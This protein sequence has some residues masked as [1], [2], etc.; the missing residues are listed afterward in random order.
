MNPARCFGVSVGSSWKGYE[1]YYWV[2]AV[3]A[4]LTHGILY[5]L[6][7]P[8]GSGLNAEK[9]QEKRDRISRVGQVEEGVGGSEK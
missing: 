5:A 6:L 2:A 3:A 8:W 7:P 4:S 1:W 9:A